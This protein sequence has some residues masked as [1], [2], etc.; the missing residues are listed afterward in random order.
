MDSEFLTQQ[1]QSAD[2]RMKE[3]AERIAQRFERVAADLRRDL[4]GA[5]D[6]G[7]VED[8]L[9][10]IGSIPHVIGNAMAG[11]ESG[12]LA[13]LLATRIYVEQQLAVAEAEEAHAASQTD[14]ADRA[15]AGE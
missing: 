13:R 8:M 14:A 7:D 12:P 9:S 1:L 6:K 5:I 2:D 15:A 3:A 4:I 11:C 10:Q